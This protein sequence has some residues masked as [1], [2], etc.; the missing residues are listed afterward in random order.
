MTKYNTLKSG[1]VICDHCYA[2]CHGKAISKAI[3]LKHS[4]CR[5]LESG[6]FYLRNEFPWHGGPPLNPQPSGSRRAQGHATVGTNAKWLST[7]NPLQR[8]LIWPL[9]ILRLR[10]SKRWGRFGGCTWPFPRRRGGGDQ[11]RARH[12]GALRLWWNATAQHDNA[13]S[14]FFLA[15]GVGS[16]EQCCHQRQLQWSHDHLQTS[17]SSD[18]QSLTN[19]QMAPST[20]PLTM[21]IGFI[22]VQHCQEKMDKG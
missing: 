16:R 9:S 8:F 19:S 6:I 7:L 1:H 12:R 10:A 17:L 18:S 2:L 15:A 4:H 11:N 13:C 20:P 21:L 22:F 5:S 14:H 3:Q